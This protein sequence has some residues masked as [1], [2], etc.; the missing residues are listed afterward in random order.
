MF[1]LRNATET[2]D[3]FLISDRNIKKSTRTHTHTPKNTLS[4]IMRTSKLVYRELVRS[5][6]IAAHSQKLPYFAGNKT[7]EIE[8]Q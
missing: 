2:T 3:A 1:S 4:R 7:K 5:Y 6:S 8:F